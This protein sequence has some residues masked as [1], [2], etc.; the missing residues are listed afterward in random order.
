MSNRRRHPRFALTNP[1]LGTLCTHSDVIV[2]PRR[3][4]DSAD[5][6]VIISQTSGEMDEK[7]ALTIMHNGDSASMTAR[8]MNSHPIFDEGCFR[9]RLNLKVIGPLNLEV[10]GP[11]DPSGPSARVPAQTSECLQSMVSAGHGDLL[12]VIGREMTVSLLNISGSGCLLAGSRP[13]EIG[14]SGEVRVVS[15]HHTYRDDLRITRRHQVTAESPV[16]FAGAEFLWARPPDTQTLRRVI[17][18]L[19]REQRPEEPREN[20][21]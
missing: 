19:Q 3:Q 21:I 1:W 8:V 18:R 5:Q 14:S 12:G 11:S 4:Q 17:R 7:L 10:I 20:T 9:H 15:H 13:F 16:C 6:V 2:E